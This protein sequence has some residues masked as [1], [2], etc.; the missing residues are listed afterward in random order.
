[1]TPTESGPDWSDGSVH[2]EEVNAQLEA[3]RQALRAPKTPATTALGTKAVDT[4]SA[5]TPKPAALA[6][7]QIETQSQQHGLHQ[8]RFV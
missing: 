5:M 3:A 4:S 1:M 6:E 2:S 8:A 7:T